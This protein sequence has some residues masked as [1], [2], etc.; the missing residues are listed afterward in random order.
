MSSPRELAVRK[1]ARKALDRWLDRVAEH[2][3]AHNEGDTDRLVLTFV[4]EYDGLTGDVAN[5]TIKAFF[6]GSEPIL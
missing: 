5:V 2:V 1:R 3:S 6:E 4:A